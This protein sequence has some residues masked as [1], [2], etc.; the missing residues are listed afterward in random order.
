MTEDE[1][2]RRLAAAVDDSGDLLDDRR[3]DRLV[4][5]RA[6]ETEI[7]ALRVA[8]RA[9]W[10]EGA[11]D[12]VLDAFRPLDEA[13][14]DKLAAVF[15]PRP[16]VAPA[17]RVVPFFGASRL[18]APGL[19]AQGHDATG[20]D[21]TGFDATGFDAPIVDIPPTPRLRLWPIIGRAAAI[22]AVAAALAIGVR[23]W[24][25]SSLGP[26]M[27]AHSAAP[28]APPAAEP[29]AQPAPSVPSTPSTP[30]TPPPPAPQPPAPPARPT[31][32]K[33][34]EPPPPSPKIEPAPSTLPRLAGLRATLERDDALSPADRAWVAGIAESASHYGEAWRLVADH[35]FRAGD[36]AEQAEALERATRRGR[37]RRDPQL[38]YSLAQAYAKAS[39]Y[40]DALT[41]MRRL[42]PVADRLDGDTRAEALRF[43][44]ILAERAVA[45]AARPAD[46]TGEARL[47]DAAL[48]R[49]RRYRAYQRGADPAAVAE[50]DERIEMLQ[51]QRARIDVP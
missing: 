46:P 50:A 23:A 30:P 22:A 6:N 28:P 14:D 41:A 2:A 11:G 37:Y 33:R 47:L 3:W 44:A 13:T 7:E 25:V 17:D 5:G 9:E 12:E 18:D 21:A 20:F 16:P 40:R 26:E 27:I 43:H 29:P 39:R 36:A 31:R 51:T 35:H 34:P 42:D 32:P 49:W 15:S 45:D 38:L 24:L 8:A 1:L 19:D 4:H 10:G 48:D